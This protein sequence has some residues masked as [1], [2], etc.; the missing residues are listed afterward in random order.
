M[1]ILS[2]FCDSSM[3]SSCV[4]PTPTGGPWCCSWSSLTLLQAHHTAPLKQLVI[5]EAMWDIAGLA[6]DVN[7]CSTKCSIGNFCSSFCCS[8][9]RGSS[10]S[11]RERK[12]SGVR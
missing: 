1:R 3:A 4:A 11:E 5:G 9:L 8:T 2:H 12:A 6:K 7:L 10:E